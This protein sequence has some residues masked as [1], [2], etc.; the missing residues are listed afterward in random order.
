MEVNE[1]TL[2]DHTEPS[3]E[4]K[5]AELLQPTQVPLKPQ[6]N[7]KKRGKGRPRKRT[8][9]FKKRQCADQDPS[10]TGPPEPL[11]PPEKW[12]ACR[13]RRLA[14][15]SFRKKFAVLAE[16]EKLYR[17]EVKRQGYERRSQIAKAMRTEERL[18]QQEASAKLSS[19]NVKEEQPVDMDAQ[20]KVELEVDIGPDEEQSQPLE[21]EKLPCKKRQKRRE[22]KRDNLP[23]L[24]HNKKARRTE[25][26]EE[27]SSRLE[28][29]RIAAATQREA[30]LLQ[31]DGST[32]RTL[33]EVNEE[34][35]FHT[36]VKVERE[37]DIGP[38]EERSQPL[39][40]KKLTNK[41]RRERKDK[42]RER[43]RG[44]QRN[45]RERTTR[46]TETEEQKSLRLKR[47]K[48]TNAM[49]RA[50]ETEVEKLLRLERLRMTKLMR[51]ATETEEEKSLRL[52]RSEKLRR[53]YQIAKAKQQEE[54]LRQQD[55]SANLSL[56]EVNEDQQLDTDVNIEREVDICSYEQQSQLL[57][58]EKL[59]CK[60][61]RKRKETDR[62]RY[63][64]LQYSNSRKEK[65][66]NETEDERSSRLERE[67]IARE[68]RRSNETEEQRFVR[69][70]IQRMA[71]LKRLV[72]ETEE[73][74][75]IRIE[76][77]QKVAQ[78]RKLKCE[79]L[80]VARIQQLLLQQMESP[81]FVVE[82]I[83]EDQ[84]AVIGI[85]LFLF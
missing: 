74:K 51:L 69:L 37:V 63:R 13:L 31:Q 47:A 85:P 45:K 65:I 35:E 8:F 42:K 16:E 3:E 40:C 27:K 14:R 15:E 71:R 24:Q 43:L 38:D 67:R 39:E 30:R 73:E 4:I 77:Q 76:K 54:A 64:R 55:G 61:R 49:R 56:V 84:K 70:E 10:P 59:T 79:S 53:Y 20:V 36:N 26:A 83:E 78:R 25:T 50:N 21:P 18:L 68:A 6:Q 19:V 1:K 34:Q 44:I 17:L 58:R 33:V 41:K 2:S 82:M 62:Q 9:N 12:T 11:E 46:R 81:N 80:R 60:R 57:Q 29:A 72:T 5:P 28:R 22:T 23:K 66:R 75:A 7:R 52:E 32:K 48:I